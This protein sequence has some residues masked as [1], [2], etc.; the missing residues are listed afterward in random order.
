M[1]IH[2]YL[3]DFFMTLFALS[4]LAL[5]GITLFGG[6]FSAYTVLVLTVPLIAG[7]LVMV[8]SQRHIPSVSVRTAGERYENRFGVEAVATLALLLFIFFSE[9][10]L[11][12]AVLMLLAVFLFLRQSAI[13]P[14]PFTSISALEKS[15]FILG[16]AV[17]IAVSIL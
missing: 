9:S 10:S 8:N 15:P 14:R 11:A 2:E 1:R 16:A 17:F 3:L 7:Y 6:S 12:M 13:C 4:S 5:W